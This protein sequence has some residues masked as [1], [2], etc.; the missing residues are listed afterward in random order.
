MVTS[1]QKLAASI[2]RFYP[3]LSGMATIAN[4]KLVDRMIGPTSSEPT[5]TR[6]RCGAEILVPLDD[7]VGRAA[8]CMGDLDGK[9][10]RIIEKIVKPGDCVL[11][12]GANLGIVTLRLAQLV[13]ELGVVHAFEPNPGL[14]KLLRD[15]IE[16]NQLRNV[17]LHGIAIGSEEGTIDL[18]FP[19]ENS[20][21]GTIS[22]ARSQ[23]GWTSIPVQV[24]LLSRIAEEFRFDRVRLVKIDV[25]GF[26]AEVLQGAE[27]W[28]AKS[29][30]DAFVFETNDKRPSGEPDPVLSLLSRYDYSFYAIPKRYLR[31][32]LTPY[33]DTRWSENIS[34]DMLAVRRDRA[35]QVLA[36]FTIRG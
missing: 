14:S 10:T 29:P 16:Q 21:K 28:L 9:L 5:W 35:E 26:E 8:F 19:R 25:E 17:H 2:G 7:Y 36:E 13:G 3:F 6:L 32:V 33:P 34:H 22:S 31:L 24:K 4:S 12:I 15:S 11:D 30:P 18:V 27:S 23:A 20:G 1:R